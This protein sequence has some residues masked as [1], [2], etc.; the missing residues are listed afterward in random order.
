[1]FERRNDGKIPLIKSGY[2]TTSCKE[3][4]WFDPAYDQCCFYG[5][6]R[7]DDIA[8]IEFQFADLE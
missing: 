8:C 3:C 1:M 4:T 7:A 2:H 6:V 5:L